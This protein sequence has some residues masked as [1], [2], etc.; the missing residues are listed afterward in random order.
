MEALYTMIM[1]TLSFNFL[2]TSIFLCVETFLKI[3]IFLFTLRISTEIVYSK[4]GAFLAEYFQLCDKMMNADVLTV[5]PNSR[6][7][8]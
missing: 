6:I 3:E 5:V 1:S 7:S 4:S 8:R 2:Y